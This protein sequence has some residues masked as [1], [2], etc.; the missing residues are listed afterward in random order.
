MSPAAGEEDLTDL[1]EV[2]REDLVRHPGVVDVPRVVR[3]LREQGRVLG[4]AA[5]LELTAQLRDHVDGLGPLQGL[6]GPEVTD[7]LVND[8][9]TVWVD[10]SSGLHRTELRL[11]AE[12]ARDLAVRLA[13]A[14]GRRLDDAVPWADAHLPSGIRF[15]AVLPPLSPGGAI[16]SLRVPGRQR[17]DLGDLVR[18][19]A[20]SPTLRAVLEQVVAARIPFL[21]TGGTGT[22]KSTLLAAMLREVTPAE[23]IV[24]VEDVLELQVEHPHVVHLQ[25]RH[26]NSEGV[27]AVDLATLVRQSLRMR[28][29]RI[30]LGEC[31]GG[32]IR[33][34]LQALNTGHEGG[35]GTVHANTA[36]DVPARLEALGALGGLD[37]QALAAQ[38]ASA[39]KVVIHLGREAGVRAVQ[40]IALLVRV[41]DGTLHARTALEVRGGALLEGPAAG[42]LSRWL[43]APTPVT[44]P[45]AG[46]R[47]AVA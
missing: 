3:V 6:L 21:V 38:V 14:G 12:A 18:L 16:L 34:L 37:R 17:L 32:E 10:D 23:R 15:H 8:D 39:L 29:D 47:R 36:A 5:M 22:G 20:I 4:A 19:G 26:A 2:V 33:E 30:V 41:A 40:E 31:R 1:V 45:S 43:H 7:L 28:P 42:D 46:H 9:G 24:V 44:G 13:T 25:S 35:C 27:G 11:D